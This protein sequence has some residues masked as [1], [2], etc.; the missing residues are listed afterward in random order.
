MTQYRYPPGLNEVRDEN[1]DPSWQVTEIMQ[2]GEVKVQEFSEREEALEELE[3]LRSED[4]PQPEVPEPQ[5][6]QLPANQP[7]EAVATDP[8][9]EGT[10]DGT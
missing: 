1:G 2:D 3:R 9:V 4:N 10:T 7:V 5:P 8:A 6:E